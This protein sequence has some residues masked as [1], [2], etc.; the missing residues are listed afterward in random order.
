MPEKLP[1]VLSDQEWTD[2]IST[3]N[4]KAP[5]GLRNA[6]IFTLMREAG[7]RV[8]E[9]IG[10]CRRDLHQEKRRDGTPVTALRLRKTKR[11]NHRN[12][13]LSDRA[14]LLLERW[15][16]QRGKHGLGD[17]PTV[18]CTL[19]GAPLKDSYLRH[20][21]ARKGEQ[22][23]FAWRMHPCALRHTF[24]TE[25]LDETGNLALVQDALGHRRPETTRVYAKV[26]N[27]ALMEAMAKQEVKNSP[28]TT[29]RNALLVAGFT[30]EQ[31][32]ALVAIIVGQDQ[33]IR[34]GN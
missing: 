20:V 4:H 14:E 13:Y 10:L 29:K 32:E 9:V 7:L 18:F 19:Q 11:G 31:V 22:A 12:V 23:G 15:L 8:C 30:P 27:S 25:L 24:A 6:A 33:P 3:Y 1:D 17:A 2:F 28:L 5:T 21:A 26:K 34:S 16:S